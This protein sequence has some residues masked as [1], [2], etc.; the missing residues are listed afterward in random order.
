M[1]NAVDNAEPETSSLQEQVDTPKTP[2]KEGYFQEI[3]SPM[4][5]PQ[6]PLFSTPSKEVTSPT[7][8]DQKEDGETAPGSSSKQASSSAKKK[9]TKKPATR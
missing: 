6:E 2:N 3:G 5:G 4:G 7:N 9:R 8:E 1:E